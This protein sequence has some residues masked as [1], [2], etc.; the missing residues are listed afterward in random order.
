MIKASYKKKKKVSV[1]IA[2]FRYESSND[3]VATVDKKGKV[4]ATGKG[5]CKIYVFTQ[6]GICKTVNVTVK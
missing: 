2:K 6:N 5:T 3:K 1:H 4:T